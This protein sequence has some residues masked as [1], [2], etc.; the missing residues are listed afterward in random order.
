MS[1]LRKGNKNAIETDSEDEDYAKL[2]LFAEATDHTLLRNDM[3]KKEL[4]VESS[5]EAPAVAA[6]KKTLPKSE[7]YLADEDAA[8][9]SDLQISKEMQTHLW[10][11]LSAIIQNQVE[12]C[13]KTDQP[14][15]GS[16]EEKE[17]GWFSQVKLLSNADCYVADDIE[18]K[19]GPQKR[20]T[21]K[22]RL[23]DVD[24]EQANTD[25][26]LAAI[27]VDGDSI[28][29]GRDMKSWAPRK[30]RKD[31]F[32]EYKATDALGRKLQAIE[33]TNEF[34]KQRRKNNWNET[35][36]SQRCRNKQ[37]KS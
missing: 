4:T 21:I 32:L 28:L 17:N 19:P 20:P 11:K 29:S 37:K 6:P 24:E 16:E 34:T 18:P 13:E 7:R 27:V 15:S 35:K 30:S 8:P 1:Y 9:V 22:R 23:L 33:P 26:A 25:A 3:Y 2:R 5:G 36:I 10:G 12:Y 14:A 31:K